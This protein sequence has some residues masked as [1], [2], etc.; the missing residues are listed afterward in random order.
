MSM[1]LS[2][3]SSSKWSI[4]FDA[5]ID[6]IATGAHDGMLIQ[7]GNHRLLDGNK[8]SGITK[9]KAGTGWHEWR[10]DN[11]GNKVSV[12]CDGALVHSVTGVGAITTDRYNSINL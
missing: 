8:I 7:V 10:F 6:F 1:V 2:T 4:V 5:K 3:A 12:Y 11:D 9:C